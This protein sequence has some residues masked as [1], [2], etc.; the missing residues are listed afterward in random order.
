M[1]V[2][3]ANGPTTVEADEILREK[4]IPVVPDILAEVYAFAQSKKTTPRTAAYALA[5]QK[6]VRAKKIR[7]I[8][9]GVRISRRNGLYIGLF[10]Y[11]LRESGK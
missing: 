8:S 5:L 11:D 1:I 10:R 9:A 7:D 4:N 2:E 6:L 3:G